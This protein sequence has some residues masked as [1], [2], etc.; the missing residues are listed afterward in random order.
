MIPRFDKL[1]V[2]IALI[3]AYAAFAAPFATFRANRIVPGQ[4][5]S[6]LEALPSTLGVLLLAIL[7]VGGIV[8]LLRTPLLLRLA[9][10][11]V[12]LVA[13][14]VLIGV[15]GGFLTPAGN[16]FARVAPA[17]GFWLLIFAFTLLLADVLTRLNLS[18]LAR[19][20]VLA[21]AALAIGALLVSGSCNSLSILKEYASRA[22]SFWAEGSKH[23]TLALGSL[24]A[25]VV[26]G[27]PLGILCHRVEALRAGVLN[28]LNIIQTIPSIA[29][30]GLLIAPLGWIVAHVPGAAEA[31]IRGIGTAPAFVALFLYSLLP[32]V[33]N[34][35]V[36][37]AGV[38][39]AAN[40]AARGMGMTDRQR[41]F[42]VEFP[43]AFPVILTGIRIVLVQNIG[44]ATIAA[45][46]GGGGFGVFV[47]QGVGQ[48][49]MD[50]VLLGAVP[51][52]ALAFAAAIILDAVIEMTSTKR[53]ADP[54]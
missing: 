15:A 43:L 26:A 16:T 28:V 30:F 49:A 5:R 41:L 51:T 48:T 21:V 46:I 31:G 29:L 52:V 35:V 32:V 37:L 34:T 25:A 38:P 45:L 40:D 27:V 2:V 50:L 39:R 24:A 4:A 11:I 9:A 53:R 19:V 22:D 6:I 33:A 54:A 17:S 36:G 14:A 42:D 23:I 44:L 7:L 47:F 3:V 8:A 20:G 10:G 1:G 12:A 18:P 13:L